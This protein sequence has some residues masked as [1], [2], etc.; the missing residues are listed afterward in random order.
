MSAT[1]LHTHTKQAEKSY[2]NKNGRTTTVIALL[3]ALLVAL[4]VR[5]GCHPITWHLPLFL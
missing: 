3:W 2:G 1:K 4:Q 5:D